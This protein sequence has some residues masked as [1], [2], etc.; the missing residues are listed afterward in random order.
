[1]RQLLIV[2]AIII[3]IAQHI[4][5]QMQ[6]NRLILHNTISDESITET[7]ID[8]TN[9]PKQEKSVLLA[10]VYSLLVPGMGELYAGSFEN[11]KY[12]LM[13][14]GGLW[15]TYAGF[16]LHSNWLRN[17]AKL[18]ATEHSNADL[19]GKDEQYEVNIGNF[20]TMEEYN[21]TKLR[22]RDYDLL[23]TGSQYNWQWDSEVNRLRFRDLRIRSS[24]IYNNS[25]FIIAAVVI[26]HVISAFSAGRAAVMFNRS[27]ATNEKLQ[28]RTYTMNNGSHINGIGLILLITF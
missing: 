11:G 17:D 15:L 19:N 24:Q 22:N 1:M 16:R 23:Y 28:I 27:I 21:Q 2:I 13:A 4:F 18:F 14:E 5:A 25:K 9:E 12:Q 8:L 7:T 20:N 3:L 26:N 6:S 10:V